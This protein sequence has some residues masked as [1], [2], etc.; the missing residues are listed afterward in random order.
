MA[1]ETLDHTVEGIEVV[2]V[3]MAR[4]K[5]E[6]VE[7]NKRW[8]NKD[9][10]QWDRTEVSKEEEAMVEA[11]NLDLMIDPSIMKEDKVMNTGKEALNNKLENKEYV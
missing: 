2:E 9:N 3:D 4:D 7:F 10:H 11:I 6:V 8:E 1:I 5:A